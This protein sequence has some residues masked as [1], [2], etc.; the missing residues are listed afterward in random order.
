MCD[1]WGLD[2]QRS[3]IDYGGLE[4]IASLGVEG[5][6]RLMADV[7]ITAYARDTPL[8]ELTAKDGM[9]TEAAHTAQHLLRAH[10]MREVE[11]QAGDDVIG[12]EPAP[13]ATIQHAA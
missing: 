10:A 11:L 9:G 1:R 8:Q 3:G 12:S 7:A 6:A 13:A 4:T 5:A 2:E